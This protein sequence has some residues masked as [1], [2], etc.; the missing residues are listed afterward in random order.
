MCIRD[1]TSTQNFPARTSVLRMLLGASY[2]LAQRYDVAFLITD[3]ITT[4]PMSPGYK[5]GIGDPWGGQNVV[6]YV[7]Y[8]LGLYKPLKDQVKQYAPEGH[9]IRRFQRY[10][11]PGQDQETVAVMLAKDKGYVDLP[12]GGAQPAK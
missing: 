12:R 11:F 1:S 7:K 4:N 9:R 8:I 2:P 10:R 6:Y 3:H 5:Y